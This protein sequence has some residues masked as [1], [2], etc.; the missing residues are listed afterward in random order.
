MGDFQV[1][2]LERLM[3]DYEQ[4]VEYNL[5]ESGVH[6]LT[7][8]E[9]LAYGG[10]LEALLATELNYPQ[11]NGT[12]ALLERIAALY[13]GAIAANVLV[14]VGAIEANYVSVQA[15]LG[16]IAVMVP[17]YM[18]IWGAAHN[19]GRFVRTFALRADDDWALDTDEL[20]RAVV[21][22][23]SLVAV[24]NPNNPTG[25]VLT[26]SE[27]EEVV[28]AADRVGAWI[29]ADE[30]YA[31][32]ERNG[33]PPTPSFWGRH[34]KVIAVNSLSKAYGLPGLRIGWIV[35]P[36]EFIQAAWRRHEYTTIAASMLSNHLAA[37]ALSSEVRPHLL[38][39]ARRY[40]TRG[41]SI[42]DAWIERHGGL[43]S[44]AAP[45]AGA[46]AF[47]RYRNG[48]PSV[49][50]ADRLRRK[51]KVLV[52]PG[53]HAGIDGHLRICFGPPAETLQAGLGRITEFL[54]SSSGFRKS[55]RSRL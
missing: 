35:A 23:T 36:T 8:G 22:S 10:H 30:V 34:D 47:V 48:M 51:K 27:M 39:R 49:E 21:P 46:M 13:D 29:L 31:G 20:H 17:D 55:A 16:D 53:S 11:V 24:C 12:D 25:S 28:R 1:F 32:A 4:T 33:A 7:L 37:L 41:W 50:F 5:T 42:L 38:A 3:S 6:P 9:L 19:L 54:A 44:C 40:V 26:E 45:T 15:A 52:V 14:T 2:E 43:L 18:Q